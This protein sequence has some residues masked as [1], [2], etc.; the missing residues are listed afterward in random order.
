M[1]TQQLYGLK[2]RSGETVYIH[3]TELRRSTESDCTM[4]TLDTIYSETQQQG[5]LGEFIIIMFDTN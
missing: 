5:V 4:F 2:R 1:K 3:N